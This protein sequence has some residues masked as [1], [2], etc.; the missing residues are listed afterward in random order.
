LAPF[1]F[2][3]GAPPKVPLRKPAVAAE[4]VS[5]AEKLAGDWGYIR[6]DLY[7]LNDNVIYFGELTFAHAGGHF[8]FVPAAYSEYFGGLWDIHRRYVRPERVP[9]PVLA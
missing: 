7:C 2:A 1:R 3:V 8:K 9:M 5:L 4:M 6:V